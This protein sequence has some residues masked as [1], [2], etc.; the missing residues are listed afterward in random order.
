[1]IVLDA[2]SIMTG[3]ALVDLVRLMEANPQVGLIQTV[4]VLVRGESFLVGP[5]NLPTGSM[6]LS[7]PPG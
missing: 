1:M 5:S 6:A 4:P 7:S 3:E 2:D